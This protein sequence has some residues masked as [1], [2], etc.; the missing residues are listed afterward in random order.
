MKSELREKA[1][2]LCRAA[3]DLEP[4]E[5]DAFLERACVGDGALLDEVKSRLRDTHAQRLIE[6]GATG[7][8]AQ[9]ASPDQTPSW[10]GRR[11]RSYEVLSRIGAGGMGEVYRAKDTKL[12]RE[13]AL[14]V[15][16]EEFAH[17]PGRLKRFEQEARSASALNHPNIIT[18][19]DIDEHDS[20]PYIAMEYVEGQTLREILIGGP[21][22]TK[23]LIPLATQMAEGL[24]KAHSAGIVHRDLKPENVMVTG[25]GFV[26]LLDFGLAKLTHEA[27]AG[28]SEETT[29]S[30]ELT[31]E[32]TIVGTLGYMS[33]EQASGR[34]VDH[35]SDQF[36]FGAVLY[37]MATGEIAF[38]RGTAAETLA[39]VIEG[40]PRPI[41]RVNPKVPAQL[42]AVVERCLSKAPGDRYD[43]TG[44]LAKELERFR[45]IRL[46][47]PAAL[48]RRT[49][50]AGAAALAA[51]GLAGVLGTNVGGLRD[52][53][54]G[55]AGPSHIDSLAVLPLTN[56]SGDPE[57]EY[58]VDG[59]TD[60]LTTDLAKIG[61]LKVISRN[62]AMGYKDTDKSIG[63]IAEELGVQAVV[64]GSVLRS[65]GRV[66]VTAQLIEAETDQ[67]LWADSFDRELRDILALYG[68]VARAIAQEIEVAVTPGE[69]T[70]LAGTRPVD[71]Q[72]YELYVQGRYHFSRKPDGLMKANELFQQAVE[73]DPSF[74]QAHAALAYSYIF[75]GNYKLLPA[76][77]VFPR[78]KTAASK[79]QEMDDA[80]AETQRALV[81]VRWSYERDWPGVDRALSRLREISPGDPEMRSWYAQRL[82]MTGQHGEAV[83]EMQKAWELDPNSSS[84]WYWAGRIP[85]FAR[86]YDR[87]IQFLQ[88]MVELHPDYT[89]SH[90]SL[91]LALLKKGMVTEA[92]EAAERGVEVSD[93]QWRW[94]WLAYVYAA[95]GRRDEARKMLRE[96]EHLPIGI[97]AAAHAVLGEKDIAFACLDEAYEAYD[98]WLF[99][100]QDPIFDPLRDDPR[101]EDLLRRL[102]HPY[103][104][105][106]LGETSPQKEAVP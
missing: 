73:A 40:E 62:S 104:A 74:T 22:P 54:L 77:E 12:G 98:S 100:L 37:E 63:Q 96:R 2:E 16:P 65:G 21:I 56:L 61:A 9:A 3:L 13:V 36:S 87:A 82:S 79:A 58:F 32:G 72:A 85:Y 24:A 68:D 95:A 41:A 93:A 90:F 69:E 105:I 97:V 71:P 15:L 7:A 28:G 25:D 20:T 18:V 33:P 44:D 29:M 83:E 34:A 91:S 10:I 19:Y 49:A 6:E 30:R 46:G 59:I 39:A 60:A 50:L 103:T 84:S 64:S 75:L 94:G 48:T 43:S 11:V 86:Q 5:R 81:S 8:G 4:G 45:E 26:K 92:L 17:D 42:R 52:R 67:Y 102:N 106:P 78:A 55:E 66:R 47:P 23:K 70:R 53:L 35:R 76:A 27:L 89:L 80:L 57:Q 31:R 1:E 88:Q 51:A 14:K 99:Q 101:F 38:K